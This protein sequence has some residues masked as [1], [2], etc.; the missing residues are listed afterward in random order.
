M[1]PLPLRRRALLAALSLLLATAIWL[2][3]VHLFFRPSGAEHAPAGPLSPRGDALLARQLA[4][5]ED[6]A[7]RARVLDRMRGS[8][9]EWDFMGRTFLVLALGNMAERRPEDRARYAAIVDRI[10]DETL[11]LE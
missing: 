8:N 5:W 3:T 6:P 10:I 4:L 1:P 2:P 7:E 11:A 9:A